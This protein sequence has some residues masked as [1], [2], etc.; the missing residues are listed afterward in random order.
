MYAIEGKRRRAGGADNRASL[1]T[2][3]TRRRVNSLNASSLCTGKSPSS[4]V[5]HQ[6]NS[7]PPCPESSRWTDF[8]HIIQRHL[9]KEAPD[10]ATACYHGKMRVYERQKVLETFRSG[11]TT[12]LLINIKCGGQG[13][14]L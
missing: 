9:Q 12:V 3:S 14:N 5:S 2:F 7:I 13:L 11:S 1:D 4:R 6:L 8:L 10:E